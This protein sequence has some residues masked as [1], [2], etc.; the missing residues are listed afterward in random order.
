LH[1]IA[2]NEE[3]AT[4][5]TSVSLPPTLCS[6]EEFE[7]LIRVGNNLK[8]NF[9]EELNYLVFGDDQKRLIPKTSES[10]SVYYQGDLEK[11]KT[12][13]VELLKKSREE[14]TILYHDLL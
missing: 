4:A 12:D 1:L 5:I 3:V 14:L 2:T 11:Y 6:L 8:V 13:L 7:N 10:V 9:D